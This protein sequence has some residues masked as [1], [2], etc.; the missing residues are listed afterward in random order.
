MTPPTAAPARTASACGHTRAGSADPP[1]TGSC[2]LQ[3]A[4]AD[5]ALRDVCGLL[6]LAERVLVASVPEASTLARVLSACL[7]DLGLDTGI[8]QARSRHAVQRHDTVV[9]ICGEQDDAQ[10]VDLLGRA[11]DVQAVLLAVT[12]APEGAL[13]RLAD[14][15]LV[16]GAPPAP[17]RPSSPVTATA[18]PP[19]P[20]SG[21]PSLDPRLVVAVDAIRRETER[22]GRY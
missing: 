15:A 7:Q 22:R 4:V 3:V 21:W 17:R 2:C 14:A 16:M 20:P 1:H 12:V 5:E 11:L 19:L 13:P 18:S 9:A 8:L 10:L 6:V